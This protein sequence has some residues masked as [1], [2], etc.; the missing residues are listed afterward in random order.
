MP[1]V[2]LHSWN[3][4]KLYSDLGEQI[5]HASLINFKFFLSLIWNHRIKCL[6]CL[7][8]VLAAETKSDSSEVEEVAEAKETT[9]EP[10][11]ETGSNEDMEPKEEN[12][13]ESNGNQM[14]FSYEQLKTKS[15]IDVAG[16]DLKRREVSRFLLILLILCVD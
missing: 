7:F 4:L 14:T 16:I 9:E 2:V 1:I 3:I 11:P 10:A 12:V 13:E 5:A 15:G 6:L 8:Q